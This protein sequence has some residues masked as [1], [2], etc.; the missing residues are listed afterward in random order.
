MDKIRHAKD[1]EFDV[2]C[3]DIPTGTRLMDAAMDGEGVSRQSMPGIMQALEVMTVGGLAGVPYK[4]LPQ[5][6]ARAFNALMVEL[7]ASNPP[8]ESEEAK[9]KK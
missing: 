1:L 9:P 6:I 8:A 5:V 4:E 7:A 2:A 3:L